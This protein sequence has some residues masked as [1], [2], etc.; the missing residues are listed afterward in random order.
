MTIFIITDKTLYKFKRKIQ[1][2]TYVMDHF[3]NVKEPNTIKCYLKEP[4]P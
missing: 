4:I 3:F 1:I 2:R